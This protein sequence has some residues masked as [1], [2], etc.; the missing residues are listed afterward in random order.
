MENVED[1]YALSPIQK[2]I[3][4]HSL[5]SP[6]ASDLYIVQMVAELQ[7]EVNLPAFERAWQLVVDHY[8]M[9]RTAFFWEDFDDPVQVVHKCLELPI[10]RH[11]WHELSAAEQT[12]KLE[13][14]LQDDRQRGFAV[15]DAPLLRLATMKLADDTYQFVLTFHVLLLD[16]WSKGL[17]FKKVLEL[18]EAISRGQERPL[19]PSQPYKH[20]I[21]WLH[22]Q[23]RAPVE[24]F[25]RQELKGFTAPTP[26]GTNGT[27]LAREQ[28]GYGDISIELDA[29]LTSRMDAFARRHRLTINT[30][31]QAA[32]ALLLSRYSGEEEVLFGSAVSGRPPALPGSDAIVGFL[33]N[34]VP[35]R[36]L[37]PKETSVL[38]WLQAFQGK[39]NALRNYEN[40]PLPEIREWSEIA[41]P[42]PLFESVVLF[43]N[44][45]DVGVLS[46][47]RHLRF[48]PLVR[49][50]Y[51]LSLCILPRDARFLIYL[52]YERN[53]F[54]NGTVPN[55]LA[56]F[57]SVITDMLDTPDQLVLRLLD[58][59]AQGVKFR[60]GQSAR[61]VL[62]H[63]D[64][65]YMAPRT[66]AEEI[67]ADMCAKVLG[68]ERIGIHDNFF[69]L[70]GHSLLATQI[71]TRVRETFRVEILL[72]YLFEAPTVAGL[73]Q[74]LMAHEAHPGQTDKIARILKQIED[75]S[76]EEAGQILQDR[77]R[78]RGKV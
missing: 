8:P 42:I 46:L 73:S 40:T 68:L 62:W 65:D 16:G 28:R 69:E 63:A 78:E 33:I 32:W 18:Y 31:V 71:I 51:P 2:G 15:S 76:D 4:L 49:T 66:P 50:M 53:R 19:G 60:A 26:V 27:G 6:D 37:V 52:A 14:S 55:I 20:Y 34:T 57:Q 9:L 21:H 48:C 75:M 29:A 24:Q 22:E 17:V 72:H 10:A 74:M 56:D 35:V 44:W 47:Y 77:R 11:D 61:H 58:G 67:L 3:L 30:L 43:E 1:I 13:T 54:S 64:R 38:S 39:Q 12:V 41:P 25:W 70:G 23:D 45:P 36:V 59:L 5:S 7:G